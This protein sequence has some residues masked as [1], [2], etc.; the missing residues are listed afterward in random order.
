MRTIRFPRYVVVMAL[1][2][3]FQSTVLAEPSDRA[4]TLSAA[5][6]GELGDGMSQAGG[7]GHGM[8]GRTPEPRM[9]R[10]ELFRRQVARGLKLDEPSGVPQRARDDLIARSATR[11]DYANS[12]SSA[13]SRRL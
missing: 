12:S 2:A 1:L 8:L 9:G 10:S 6:G 3:G 13:G 11:L 7:I 4:E 5:L